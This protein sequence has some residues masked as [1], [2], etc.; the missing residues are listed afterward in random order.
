MKLIYSSMP[1]FL[2]ITIV[3]THA[4]DIN[5]GMKLHQEN[6]TR[7]HQ[8]EIYLHED[9]KVKTLEQLKKQVQQ[10]ELAIELAWFEEEVDDVTEYLNASYY[11]FGMK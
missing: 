4:T 1:F 2:L 8:P 7:C 9:R 11:L 6:C 10:C 5:N 3:P